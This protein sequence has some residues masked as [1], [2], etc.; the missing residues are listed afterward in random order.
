MQHTKKDFVKT[1]VIIVI[2]VVICAGIVIYRSKKHSV[3]PRNHQTATSTAPIVVNETATTTGTVTIPQEPNDPLAGW[4]KYENT[5]IGLT[6]R[7]PKDFFLKSDQFSKMGEW[8]ATF[9]SDRG[10]LNIRVAKAITN[11]GD[12]KTQTLS[13]KI[14]TKDAILYMTRRD[15]CDVGVAQTDL[16]TDNKI[17]FSFQSC[18]DKL[19]SIIKDRPDIISMLDSV[20][21]TTA[22]TKLL[23]DT[24]LKMAFRYPVTLTAPIKKTTS[25]ITGINFGDSISVSTGTYYNPQLKKNMTAQEVATQE[26]TGAELT[27][28]T[29]DDRPAYK[30]LRIPKTGAP[31]RLLYAAHTSETTILA[32]K[33]TGL[34]SNDLDTIVHTFTFIK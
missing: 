15:V 24:G 26:S 12:I 18:G 17:E 23:V 1:V 29:L 16:D 7:Y 10:Q 31:E 27:P 33:Q 4:K 13:T 8:T 32:I 9:T 30:I 34:D 14:D 6:F 19:G 22:N 28:T 21:F 2:I 25:T 11:T 3:T 20:D 5:T